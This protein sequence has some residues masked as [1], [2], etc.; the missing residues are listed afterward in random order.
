MDAPD[1]NR[2]R[3]HRGSGRSPDASQ[4]L[5][6]W[7]IYESDLWDVD[8]LDLVDLATM[9]I[10]ASG[11]GEFAFGAMVCGMDIGFA[12][13]DDIAFTF[14]GSDEGMEI[15]GSGFAELGE[16]GLLQID[17]AF[18]GGDDAVLKARRE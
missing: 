7:R 14:A 6:T 15:S 2:A 18:H 17:L 3:R 11:F 12:G 1:R 16:D 4:L 10:P 13:P 5:G 8:F 9:M